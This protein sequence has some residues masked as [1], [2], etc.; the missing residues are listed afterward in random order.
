[1]NGFACGALILGCKAI[2]ELT[3]VVSQNLLNFHRCDFSQPTQKVGTAD[4]SLVFVNAQINS[5]R[6][7][8]NGHKEIASLRLI[9]HLRQVLDVNV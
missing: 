5:S 7:S 1:R 2:R 8:I 3:P 4:V 6:R 9:R